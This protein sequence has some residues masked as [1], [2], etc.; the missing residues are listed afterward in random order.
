MVSATSAEGGATPVLGSK[1]QRELC[2]LGLLAENGD[3]DY[4]TRTA[5]R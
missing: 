2:D 5:T 1:S 3:S 4:G